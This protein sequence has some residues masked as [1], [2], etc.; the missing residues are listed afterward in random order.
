MSKRF[1]SNNNNNNNVC[2]AVEQK[3]QVNSLKP[4]SGKTKVKFTQMSPE[5]HLQSYFKLLLEGYKVVAR[6]RKPFDIESISNPVIKRKLTANVC[7]IE[8]EIILSYPLYEP[9]LFL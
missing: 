4:K 3:H 5:P 2:L 8:I 6:K 1:N 7:E 9:I